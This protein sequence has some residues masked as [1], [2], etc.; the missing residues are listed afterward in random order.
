ML[1]TLDVLLVLAMLAGASWTFAQKYGAEATEHE[2]AALDRKIALERE[3]IQLLQADWSL[4]N[5]PMRIEK[6]AR[7]FDADLKLVPVQPQQIIE[8]NGLPSAPIA[9]P[10]EKPETLASRATKP[11]GTVR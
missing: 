3:T 1:K 5:Q 4:L 10:E 2:V 8:P 7:A 11:K 6:L 9:E